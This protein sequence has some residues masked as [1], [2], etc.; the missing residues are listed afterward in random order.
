MMTAKRGIWM[1]LPSAG[2][3]ELKETPEHRV[4]DLS[5]QRYREMEVVMH[6]SGGVSEAGG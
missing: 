2:S 1:G 6:R 5:G 4:V 3:E